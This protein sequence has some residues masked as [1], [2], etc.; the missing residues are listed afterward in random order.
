MATVH[1]RVWPLWERAVAAGRR[2][3]DRIRALVLHR[4]MVHTPLLDIYIHKQRDGN[5]RA[6]LYSMHQ[7]VGN[8]RVFFDPSERLYFY[9]PASL[10]AFKN[11]APLT[12]HLMDYN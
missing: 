3:D 1:R 8:W 9:V 5:W 2:A 10:A 7:E 12:L 4:A 11:V 6:F